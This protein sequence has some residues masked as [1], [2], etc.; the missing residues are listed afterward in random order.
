MSD[1]PRT[2]EAVHEDET[3]HGEKYETVDP[4]FARQLERELAAM[5]AAAFDS[6]V[7]AGHYQL[8]FDELHIR[9]RAMTAAKDKAVEALK[10]AEQ[11]LLHSDCVLS[12]PEHCFSDAGC[13][14]SMCV[15]RKDT[16]LSVLIAE[17]GAV[18]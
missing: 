17:L 6:R 9:F 11:E 14:C 1:T 7:E 3:W 15:L 16:V 10:I 18:K 4:E 8:K 5:T 12:C 2:D 13:R